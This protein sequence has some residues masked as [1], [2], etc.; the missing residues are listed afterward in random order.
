MKYLMLF[1]ILVSCFR[2]SRVL[3]VLAGIAQGAEPVDMQRMATV[4]KRKMLNV[5][6]SVSGCGR[7]QKVGVVSMV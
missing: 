4:I 7:R 2:S 1:L 3:A 6:N 5:A